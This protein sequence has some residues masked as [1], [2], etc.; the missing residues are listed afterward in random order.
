MERMEHGNLI[1]L[2]IT[3]GIINSIG[4]IQNNSSEKENHT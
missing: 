1:S 2:R 4:Y 3:R